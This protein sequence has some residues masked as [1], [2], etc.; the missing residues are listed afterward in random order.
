MRP[1]FSRSNLR[2]LLRQQQPPLYKPRPP[3]FNPCGRFSLDPTRVVCCVSSNHLSI[4]RGRRIQ[5]RPRFFF[6]SGERKKKS[7]EKRKKAGIRRKQRRRPRDAKDQPRF[8][9][10]CRA[11]T[12]L[13]RLPE[14]QPSAQNAD[15][16]ALPP[17]TAIHGPESC[18]RLYKDSCPLFVL[19]AMPCGCMKVWM[20]LFSFIFAPDI[21]EQ[22][23]VLSTLRYCN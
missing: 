19:L 15:R 6:L 1:F 23:H 22:S 11:Y 4:N 17:L 3:G 18:G 7:A 12:V 2:G 8:K 9:D 10:L 21:E 20:I 14:A 16:S 5:P 13:F